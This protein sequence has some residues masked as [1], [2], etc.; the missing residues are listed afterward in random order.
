MK[1]KVIVV[2]LLVISVLV[3]CGILKD[4]N[5]MDGCNYNYECIFYNDIY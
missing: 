2:F 4:N 1:V 3:V 5:V